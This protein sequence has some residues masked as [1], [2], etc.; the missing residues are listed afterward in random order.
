MST[1]NVE[2]QSAIGKKLILYIGQR[3][4]STFKVDIASCVDEDDSRASMLAFAELQFHLSLDA[5]LELFPM[6][7]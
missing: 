1:L 7:L 4:V 2:I 5:A 3:R 6:L